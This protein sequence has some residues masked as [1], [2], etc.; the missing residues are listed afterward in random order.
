MFKRLSALAALFL[1]AY[2]TASSAQG[3]N[4]RWDAS[5]L[6]NDVA[7]PFRFEIATTG[8]SA[9]GFFFDG[10]RKIASTSGRFTD[11]RLTLE[12][13]FLNTVLEASFDGRELRGFYRNRRPNARPMNFVASPYVPAAASSAT[14]VPQIA[15]EWVMYRTAQDNNQL[16]VSWRLHLSESGSDVSGA[17]LRTSG[18]TGMLTGAWRDGRLTLSHFAGERPLLFEA[19]LARDGMLDITLDRKFTYR[20]VR[21]A[22]LA[23]TGI[24]APPNLTQFTG[25]NNA[26]EPLR[27][28]GVDLEGTSVSNADARFRGKVVVL[29]IGGTWCA[30]CHDEAPFLSSLYNEFHAKGLEVVG[31]F[32]EN[33]ADLA[34]VRP[35]I[36]AFIK[37]YAVAYPIVFAGTTGQAEAKLSQLRNF[38]VFPTTIII[39]R[40]GLV[41]RVQA[42]FASAATGGE[43]DRL[44]R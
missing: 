1:F 19:R 9:V 21:S 12:Y 44:V 20:A 26:R 5:V 27:F 32:F 3:I 2:V 6:A 38:S 37:R 13:D 28:S 7:V 36:V 10:S 11:G 18:D 33:D 25:V 42:G 16:D 15:G 30:N 43:H 34:V 41:R 40:D 8:T 4:G 17:I 24:P 31:L 14:G 29:T 39:G 23:G 22:R 35:R